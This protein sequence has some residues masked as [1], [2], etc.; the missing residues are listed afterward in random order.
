ML[1]YLMDMTLLLEDA[2][3]DSCRDGVHPALLSPQPALAIDY[4]TSSRWTRPG[5]ATFWL[6]KVRPGVSAA[7]ESIV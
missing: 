1:G 4:A 3:L 6:D 7:T 2:C 5:S